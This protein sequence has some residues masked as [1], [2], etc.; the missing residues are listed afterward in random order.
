M[1]N[2]LP[3]NLNI[4]VNHDK[5]CPTF[6]LAFKVGEPFNKSVVETDKILSRLLKPTPI[7]I[8]IYIYMLYTL[9]PSQENHSDD[10]TNDCANPNSKPN[11]SPSPNLNHNPNHN[12][13]YTSVDIITIYT[14]PNPLPNP[15]FFMTYTLP[16][17]P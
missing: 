4:Y 1:G 14:N 17:A 7:Y 5:S 16:L 8:Y 11:P 3:P 13:M 2:A 6:S 10:N 12:P 15:N 9:P